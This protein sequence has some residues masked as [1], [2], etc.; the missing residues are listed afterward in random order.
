MFIPLNEKTIIDKA[1]KNSIVLDI[2]TEGMSSNYIDENSTLLVGNI[3]LGYEK[4]IQTNGISLRNENGK[5]EWKSGKMEMPQR[6]LKLRSS[7]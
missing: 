2:V 6:P 7:P 4:S 5:M 3:P 1:Y